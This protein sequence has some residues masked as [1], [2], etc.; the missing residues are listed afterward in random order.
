MD[1]VACVCTTRESHGYEHA[2][3]L[4]CYE[5]LRICFYENHFYKLATLIGTNVNEYW[6]DIVAYWTLFKALFGLYLTTTKISGYINEHNMPFYSL[7]VKLLL[8]IFSLEI[9]PILSGWSTGLFSVVTRVRNLLTNFAWFFTLV[10]L[11]WPFVRTKSVVFLIYFAKKT[12]C[13]KWSFRDNDNP[14]N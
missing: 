13:T 11:S 2:T 8:K 14:W 1:K 4:N 10:H 6:K 12:F 3:L 9:K 5:D 7:G